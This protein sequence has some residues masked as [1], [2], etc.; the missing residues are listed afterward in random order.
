M[1]KSLKIKHKG[2][3]TDLLIIRKNFL[4]TDTSIS[5]VN[6]RNADDKQNN[7]AFRFVRETKKEAKAQDKQ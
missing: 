1:T 6:I 2:M 3:A 4:I 5:Y 7:E